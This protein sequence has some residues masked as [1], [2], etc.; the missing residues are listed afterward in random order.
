MASLADRHAR[1]LLTRAR[2][3]RLATVD[4]RGRPH[5]VPIVFVVEG[6]TLVTA[7]DQK[8][9]QTA[10]LQ[11]IRNI[12]REPRVALL[13]DHYSEDWDTLWWVRADGRATVLETG[14]A[15][16]PRAILLLQHKYPQYR[17]APPGGPVIEIDIERLTGWT[18]RPDTGDTGP[19]R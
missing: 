4:G 1:R 16:R 19:S 5:L 15:R 11:R 18:A 17:S 13:V 8:P 14:D 3:A 2:I 10:D 6:S 9:K 7:V 12:G